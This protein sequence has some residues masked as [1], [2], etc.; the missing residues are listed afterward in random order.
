MKQKCFYKCIGNLDH[1]FNFELQSTFY[2]TERDLSKR[3]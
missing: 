2:E 1:S 3:H